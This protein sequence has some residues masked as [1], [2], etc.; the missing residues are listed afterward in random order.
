MEALL[1]SVRHKKHV[2][3]DW[4]GTIVD[5]MEWCHTVINGILDEEGLN[6]ITPRFYQQHFC[7]PVRNFYE[8]LGFNFEVHCFDA[9]SEKF[10]ARYL[11]GADKLGLRSG[12]KSIFQAIRNLK[13][14]QSILSASNE[15]YLASMVKS[16]DIHHWFDHVFGLNNH[17]A[18]SKIERGL[19]LMGH[20][21]CRKEDT[22][23]IGDTDHD[24]E[25]AEALGI[26]VVLLQSGHQCPDKLKQT[27]PEVKMFY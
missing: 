17:H 6:T 22:I 9:L 27:F 23:L 14:T 25:V 12:V 13:I 21:N 3:W 10:I 4:N 20:T 24:V 15:S 1:D 11:S 16:Y 18:S 19:D 5:D 8:K 7:F 26:D 2:I